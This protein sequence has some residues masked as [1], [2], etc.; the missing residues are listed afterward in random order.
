MDRS[1]EGEA[2]RIS[3]YECIQFCIHSSI[4]GNF[5]GVYCRTISNHTI[6]N[7]LVHVS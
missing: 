3:M 1:E 7:I 2:L 4:G 6:R 5:S